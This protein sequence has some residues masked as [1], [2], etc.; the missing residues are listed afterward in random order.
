MSNKYIGFGSTI[1]VDP[2]G[3][4]TF[5]TIAGIDHI[6]RGDA[7]SNILDSSTLSQSDR[8]ETK[9]GG[10]IDPGTLDMDMYYDPA[11]ATQKTLA[12]L[13]STQALAAWKITYSDTGVSTESFKA[14]V[15][16]LGQEIPKKELM[17]RKVK[18]AVSG[19]PGFATA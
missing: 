10:L 13:L 12:L 2:A 17:M 11:E 14:I 8:W 5:A 16:S 3:G 7:S 9:V 4:T 19:N 1:G 6:S 15:Q 18:L